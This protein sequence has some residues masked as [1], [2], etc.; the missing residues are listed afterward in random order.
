[1]AECIE[2]LNNQETVNSGVLR[3]GEQYASNKRKISHKIYT[4]VIIS[5]KL[6]RRNP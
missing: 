4:S 5:V 6:V 3:N 2:K 1:M